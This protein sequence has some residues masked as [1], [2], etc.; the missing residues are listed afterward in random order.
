MSQAPVLTA[1]RTDGSGI[2]ASLALGLPRRSDAL[3]RE[4]VS[5][6]KL[7]C[8]A[9]ALRR[10]DCRGRMFFQP[11]GDAGGVACRHECPG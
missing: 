10:G 3:R 8:F 7:A 5:N 6:A 2:S 4:G 1:P 9:D 11:I